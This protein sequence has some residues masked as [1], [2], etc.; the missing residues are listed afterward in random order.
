MLGGVEAPIAAR[1]EGAD[2][3]REALSKAFEV[4]DV[5]APPKIPP[6]FTVRFT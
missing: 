4:F 2:A 5:R 6:R 1:P 3:T